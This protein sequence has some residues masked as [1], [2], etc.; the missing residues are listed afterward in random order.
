MARQVKDRRGKARQ[1]NKFKARQGKAGQV[2]A[3]KAR[4]GKVWLS[5]ER[6]S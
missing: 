4:L 3:M 1:D 6:R 5:K 2:R